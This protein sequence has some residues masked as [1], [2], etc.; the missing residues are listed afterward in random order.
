MLYITASASKTELFRRD[1]LAFHSPHPVSVMTFCSMQDK[2][3]TCLLCIWQAVRDKQNQQNSDSSM[4]DFNVDMVVD[5]YS[6]A[7]ILY[8]RLRS[9]NIIIYLWN[10]V[11]LSKNKGKSGW[12]LQYLPIR[13]RKLRASPYMTHLSMKMNHHHWSSE[14]EFR[15]F[16]NVPYETLISRQWSLFTPGGDLP[17]TRRLIFQHGTLRYFQQKLAQETSHYQEYSYSTA[18]KR[19]QS[20]MVQKYSEILHHLGCIK[21]VVNSGI[22]YQA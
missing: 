22:N 14:T 19:L 9:N 4:I 7:L 13:W 5:I 21:P 11:R 16:M 18:K 10:G 15:T 8:V 2:R 6:L 1:L 3:P 12:Y 17:T 20:S